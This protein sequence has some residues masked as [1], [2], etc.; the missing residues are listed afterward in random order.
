MTLWTKECAFTVVLCMCLYLDA[1]T[2]NTTN[3][4][5]HESI[6][7]PISQST[8]SHAN[9]YTKEINHLHGMKNDFL[10]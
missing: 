6:H 10:R 5:N 2:H 9:T 3:T 8:F 7:D 4:Q 1:N